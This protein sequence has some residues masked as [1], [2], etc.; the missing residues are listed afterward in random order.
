MGAY[1]T[2]FGSFAAGYTRAPVL[3]LLA[4]FHQQHLI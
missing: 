1:S 2:G 3:P 4:I